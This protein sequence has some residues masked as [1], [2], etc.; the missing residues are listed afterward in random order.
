VRGFALL[1]I[2]LANMVFYCQPIA[3]ALL[4]WAGTPGGLDRAVIL[5]VRLLVE[6]KFYALFSLLFGVGF[7]LQLARAEARGTRFGWR[8]GR[9][10]VGLAIF[11]LLHMLFLWTGDILHIYAVT[12]SLLLLFRKRRPRTVLWWALALL[13]VSLLFQLVATVMVPLLRASASAAAPDP[14]RALAALASQGWQAYGQGN[15]LAVSQQRARD[16]LLFLPATLITLPSTLAFFLIGLWVARR[17]LLQELGA[18]RRLP[19]R[20]LALCL[21]LGLA[22][23]VLLMLGR[24]HQTAGWRLAVGAAIFLGAPLLTIGYAAGLVLLSAHGRWRRR[25][26]PLAAAG[27]MALSNYLLQSLICSTLFYGYGFGLLGRFGPATA[28][29]LALAIWTAQL[30]WSRLWLTHFRSGPA[31]WLWRS[32]TYLRWQPLRR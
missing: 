6:A 14:R 16:A 29:T 8:Y 22:I 21:P 15:F 12:G 24:D 28:S 2:L 26:A 20:V 3:V 13:L 7:G 1:G 9:R 18:G 5:L 17:G 4:G 32:F 10:L 30:A 27:R 19:M 11:G 23:N 25:L 31:E